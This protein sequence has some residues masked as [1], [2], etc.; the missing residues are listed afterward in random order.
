MASDETFKC[1]NTKAVTK[2]QHIYCNSSQRKGTQ[3]KQRKV[4]RKK[5]ANFS[6]S[7][8]P[9]SEEQINRYNNGI[10]QEKTKGMLLGTGL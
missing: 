4:T 2:F 5:Y 9:I 6:Q 10:E 3:K 1:E 8:G 7:L